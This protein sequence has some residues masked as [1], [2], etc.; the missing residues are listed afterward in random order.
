MF[1]FGTIFWLELAKIV[2]NVNRLYFKKHKSI[3]E[4]KTLHTI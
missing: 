4:K 2:K 3:N 1:W